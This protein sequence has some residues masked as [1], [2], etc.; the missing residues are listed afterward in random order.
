M[1]NDSWLMAQGALAG[2]PRAMRHE[3]LTIDNQ[4]I[5]ELSDYILDVLG[6]RYSVLSKK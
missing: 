2:L 1:V 3:P 5:H 4:L 6:F